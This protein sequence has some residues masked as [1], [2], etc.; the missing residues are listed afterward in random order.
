MVDLLFVHVDSMNLPIG[1]G[2]LGLL[3]TGG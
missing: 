1:W 2:E 3:N